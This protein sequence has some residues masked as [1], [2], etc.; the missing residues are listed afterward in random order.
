[1]STFTEVPYM[2]IK[3]KIIKSVY[4]K[5]IVCMTYVAHTTVSNEH[6]ELKIT[7]LF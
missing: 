7:G 3:E 1:M 2:V 4:Y 6:G 5:M